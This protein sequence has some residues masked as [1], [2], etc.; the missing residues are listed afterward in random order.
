MSLPIVA[1][2]GPP[3]AGKSTLLNKLAGGQLAVTSDIPGT[4]R[5]RQYIDISWNSKQFTLVDT[6]GLELKAHGEL[7]TQVSAQIDIASTEA[8]MLLFVVD[9]KLPASATPQ[10]TI[11]KF[12]ST[13][14]PTVL[15]I[16]K[17]DSP[18]HLEELTAE[19]SKLGIK[20]I[21]PVSALTGRGTG[22]LLD[23]IASRL[24]Q[25]PS[26]Q[27]VTPSSQ[28][29][30]AV[31]IVGKPNVGKSSLFNTIVKEERVVVSATPGTTRT[32]IDSH[33][34]LEG[35]NYTFIDTAGLKKKAY[36]QARPDVYSG[37]QT[38]KAIRRSDIAMLVVDATE[39]VTFQDQAI[40]KEIFKLE[41]GC[42]IVVTKM[43]VYKGSRQA[44]QDYISHHFPFLWMC[45]VFFTS[46]KTGEGVTQA[47]AALK[48]IYDARNKETPEE[49]INKLLAKRLK[50][51]PPKLLRD[52]KK[53]KVLGLS[54]TGTNPPRFELLVNH[55]A[56]ISMQFRKSVQNSIIKELNY[57][58]TP[59]LL[60][61]KKKM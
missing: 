56:A 25:P 7:E 34:T 11:K 24:P 4:T 60:N 45:P 35:T 47:L 2:V 51:N 58:G 50:I 22:D 33:I 26:P 30:I 21:F 61:L 41:K 43:D 37:F 39:P 59:V 29:S 6:A 57:W 3:N 9:G 1:I 13:T 55:P 36:R 42:I 54:Q 14:K 15:V 49:D 46:S 23:Y 32:A 53:P 31:A 52:Q 19:F 16:N 20:T 8:D 28:P 5:D 12:R 40:A 10:A 17:A 27:P 48:P 18:K 44:L 38:Y